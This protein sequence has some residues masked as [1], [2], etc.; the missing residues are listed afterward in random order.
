MSDTQFRKWMNGL[1]A[2]RRQCADWPQQLIW[3]LEYAFSLEQR[4]CRKYEGKQILIDRKELPI[5]NTPGEK[6]SAYS[7]YHSCHENEHSGLLSIEGEPYWLISLEVPN[8]HSERGRRADLLGLSKAGGL[9]VFECKL[10]ENP[11]S[12]M[13]AIL[14]GLDYLACLTCESNFV[15]IQ[16]EFRKLPHTKQPPTDFE[17]VCPDIDA[18]HEVIVLADVAY[19]KHHSR[20]LCLAHDWQMLT[21]MRDCDSTVRLSLAE[22]AINDAGIYSRDDVRWCTAPSQ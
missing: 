20:R 21:K 9:C 8:Q 4:T 7:L 18:R 15:R 13:A 3:L 11:Y 19:Y 17:N 2:S 1:L 14:E 12:P 6:K 22:A 5:P 16:E 10:D